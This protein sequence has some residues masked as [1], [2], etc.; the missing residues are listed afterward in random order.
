MPPPRRALESWLEGPLDERSVLLIVDDLERILETPKPSDGRPAVPAMASTAKRSVRCSRPSPSGE[1]LSTAVT[2]RY[3]FRPPDGA[4]GDHAAG[5]VRVPLRPMEERERIK[6]CARRGAAAERAGGASDG[7][8]PALARDRGGRRQ[9]GAAG[10]PDAADPGRR[11]CGGGSGADAD[12]RLSHDRR[13]ARRDPG[14]DRGREPRAIRTTRWS[15]FFQPR[16]RSRPM[17]RR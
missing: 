2:S 10:D 15:A 17:A 12:R 7:P 9:S 8:E 16:C 14:A 1:P 5:L 13:A 6:Q 3:D 4:G 11:A